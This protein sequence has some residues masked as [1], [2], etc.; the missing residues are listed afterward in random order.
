MGNGKPPHSS[1]ITRHSSLLTRYSVCIGTGF[2]GAYTTF[3]TFTY[4]TVELAE[5]HAFGAAVQNALVSAVVPALAA[6]AGLALA[7]L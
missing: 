5:E 3:S 2:C 1:L 7:A 6:A 4:E